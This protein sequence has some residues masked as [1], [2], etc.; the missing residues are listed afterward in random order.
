MGGWDA[1]GLTEPQPNS[2]KTVVSQWISGPG[3]ASLTGTRG[4]REV[5]YI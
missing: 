5:L 1:E 3:K 4:M 2:I